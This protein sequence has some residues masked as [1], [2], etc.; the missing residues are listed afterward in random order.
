ML[1]IEIA[2]V[3]QELDN[4]AK[5]AAKIPADYHQQL[6]RCECNYFL[7]FS[8]IADGYGTVTADVA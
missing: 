3:L 1:Y 7:V 5:S 2:I 4:R 6:C 8:A